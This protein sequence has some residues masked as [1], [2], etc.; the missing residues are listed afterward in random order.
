VSDVVPRDVIVR[1]SRS[2]GWV[3]ESRKPD[4]RLSEWWFPT[5]GIA[6][7]A[8][9]KLTDTDLNGLASGHVSLPPP[10]DDAGPEAPTSPDR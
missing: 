4:G 5:K 8:G 7:A 9:R 2:F 6:K 10:R 1:P 3:V